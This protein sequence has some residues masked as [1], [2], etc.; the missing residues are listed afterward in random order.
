MM[1]LISC[2]PSWTETLVDC[3]FEVVGRTRYCV[4][5]EA[6]RSATVVG[7]TKDLDWDVV[8]ALKPDGLILDREENPKRFA[9]EAT[10][11]W[12]A[13][14]VQS[15]SDVA[16]ALREIAEFTRARGAAESATSALDRVAD[17]WDQV[18]VSRPK[19]T[20]RRTELASLPGVVEWIRRPEESDLGEDFLVTY[21]IWKN[22]WMAVAQNTFIGSM[23]GRIGLSGKI[24]KHE[25]KYPEIDLNQLNPERDLLLFSTEP[26]PFLKMR[27][28]LHNLPFASALVDGEMFSWFGVRSLNF[29]EGLDKTC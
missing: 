23:L 25:G 26:F 12:V 7:G 14:T 4:H 9:D 17:R 18:L 27:R 10:V 3:G 8:G 6:A 1:R 28:D 20:L 29:L 13:S 22:P 15:V 24:T 2:V 5:P 19:A 16:P 21:V 11:P